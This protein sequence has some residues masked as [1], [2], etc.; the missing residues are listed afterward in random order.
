MGQILLRGSLNCA[1]AEILCLAMET[2]IDSLLMKNLQYPFQHRKVYEE[3]AQI[4]SK[5]ISDELTQEIK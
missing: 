5:V 3:S 4:K 1:D 2:G